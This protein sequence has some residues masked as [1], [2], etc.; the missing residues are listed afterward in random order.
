MLLAVGA[1]GR[2]VRLL[3]EHLQPPL[4]A[5]VPVVLD[6]VVGSTQRGSNSNGRSSQRRLAESS[7]L[8]SPAG[9]DDRRS[10]V[11]LT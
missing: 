9:I 3:Q 11:K 6:V 1:V 4:H 5:R 10:V 7:Q 2:P 8:T